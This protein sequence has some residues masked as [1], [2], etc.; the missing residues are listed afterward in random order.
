MNKRIIALVLLASMSL[1]AVTS[2]STPLETSTPNGTTESAIIITTPETSEG[3]EA[4]ETE[5]STEATTTTAMTT[6]PFEPVD[7]PEN[8]VVPEGYHFVWSDEFDGEELSSF[9]TRESHPSHWVNEELQEYVNSE[10]YAYVSGGNLIIQPT[11]VVGEDGKVSYYSGRVNTYGAFT[12]QYGRIEAKIKTPEGKGYL[13]A[14]WLLPTTGK[15]PVSGEIDIM[16][17]VGGIGTE[18]TTYGTIH[19]GNPHDQ[20]QGSYTL[21]DG[22]FSSDYHIYACEWEPGKITFLVDGIPFY[23]TTEWY[24]S[25]MTGYTAEFPAPF[26]KPFYIIFNV[27]VGGNWPGDPDDNTPFDERGQMRVDWVRVY[28]RDE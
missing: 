21:E 26:D 19:Y 11:K 27:A 10:E 5:E 23:E 13:P 7:E 12:F 14:F 28:Q 22:L 16:E 2:C 3:T 4:S 8:I 6:V 25:P 9:W 20:N 18:N 24:S 1:Y 15:W 17:I